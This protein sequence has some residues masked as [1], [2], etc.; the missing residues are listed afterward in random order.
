MQATCAG[1]QL[2]VTLG[3]GTLCGSG[4]R[5]AACQLMYKQLQASVL[6]RTVLG[7]YLRERTQRSRAMTE[8]A[9]RLPTSLP[10]QGRAWR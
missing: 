7:L 6:F 1:P 9:S 3:T 2:A 10:Q 8:H 5:E 4:V